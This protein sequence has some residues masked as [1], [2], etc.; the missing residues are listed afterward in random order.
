MF[1]HANQYCQ[2]VVSVHVFT[3]LCVLPVKL[4]GSLLL[5]GGG[6]IRYVTFAIVC[7]RCNCSDEVLKPTKWGSLSVTFQEK[8]QA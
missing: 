4:L 3:N 2:F 8:V 6:A 5:L 1:S 7:S